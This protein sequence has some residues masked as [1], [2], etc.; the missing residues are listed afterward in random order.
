MSPPFLLHQP[1]LS[2]PA[3]YN[4]GEEGTWKLPE[5]SGRL[6]YTDEQLANFSLPRSTPKEQN[7]HCTHHYTLKYIHLLPQ[8]ANL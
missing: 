3:M 8:G 7:T 2:P 1:I 5:P 6:Q 4:K